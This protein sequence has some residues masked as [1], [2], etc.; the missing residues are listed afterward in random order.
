[1]LCGS[2]WQHGL[3]RRIGKCFLVPVSVLVLVLPKQRSVAMAL[4]VATLKGIPKQH[5]F[6]GINTNIS[7]TITTALGIEGSMSFDMLLFIECIVS[8]F[9]LD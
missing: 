9:V 8:S 6:H 4:S 7:T 1:M 5:A 3:D 2:V